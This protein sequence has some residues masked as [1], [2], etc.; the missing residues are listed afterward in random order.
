[1]PPQN[2][3]IPLIWF[4]IQLCHT[5]NPND[6]ISCKPYYAGQVPS[7]ESIMWAHRTATKCTAH[8]FLVIL[9]VNSLGRATS[10]GLKALL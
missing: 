3:R 1:M 10:C 5:Y 2:N 8:P 9:T 6:S 4:Q 7:H